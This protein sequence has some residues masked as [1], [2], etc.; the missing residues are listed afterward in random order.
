M[1]IWVSSVALFL[2]CLT[3]SA[4]PTSLGG[5]TP[6]KTTRMELRNTVKTFHKVDESTASVE[7]KDPV[8]LGATIHFQNDVV[9]E[10]QVLLQLRPELEYAL[11]EKYGQLYIHDGHFGRVTCQ[12]EF[13]ATAMRFEGSDERRWPAKDG[14]QGLIARRAGNCSKSYSEYYVLRHVATVEAMKNNKAD[15]VKKEA[16]EERRKLGDAF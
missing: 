6:G 3:A 14:V 9:Y 15:Q 8:G 10:V 1:K 2:C 4:Q 7:F 12:N 16:E 5:I 13:G 11:V